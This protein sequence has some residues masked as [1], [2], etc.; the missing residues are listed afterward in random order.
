MQ[1]VSTQFEDIYA[2]GNYESEIKVVIA[3][4]EYYESSLMDVSI[5][6]ELFGGNNV[7]IGS[8]CMASCTLTLTSDTM[9]AR[10]MSAL[11]PRGARVE[12]WERIKGETRT[13]EWINQGVFFVDSR[14][15]TS[16]SS[17]LVLQ[18]VDS[19]VKADAMYPGTEDGWPSGGR[20]DIDVVRA[21]AEEMGVTVDG[22]TQ[23]GLNY[24]IPFP[25][26]YTMREVLSYIGAMYGGN[27]LIT[28]AGKLLLLK[29]SDLPEETNYL[30]T[31]TGDP[32]T[33]GGVR[34]LVSAE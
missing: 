10:D 31:N 22:D 1:S 17:R 3:G 20:T 21:I 13:S 27:W 5:K 26:T 4:T 24:K 25:G 8:A 11:I 28:K 29:L 18:C 2:S 7:A 15:A 34:I 19:M 14:D 6:R 33:F 32:I 16:W 9:T 23:L 12:V 30:I